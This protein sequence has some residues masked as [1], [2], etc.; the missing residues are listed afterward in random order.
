MRLRYRP[1]TY[2]TTEFREF[3]SELEEVVDECIDAGVAPI[4]SRELHQAKAYA[5]EVDR[6]NF[7]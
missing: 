6:Q 7:L 2:N 4:I 3:L 5:M 1:D